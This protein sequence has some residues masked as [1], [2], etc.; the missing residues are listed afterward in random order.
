[1][2]INSILAL[3]ISL[4]VLSCG[5]SQSSNEQQLLQEKEAISQEKT[6]L[7]EENRKLR[8]TEE[9]AKVLQENQEKLQE[10]L[11]E[12]ENAREQENK[13][14][15]TP[16]EVSEI[17]VSNVT[18]EGTLIDEGTLFEYSKVKYIKYYYH[19]IDNAVIAGKKTNGA[20]YYRFLYKENGDWYVFNSRGSFITNTGTEKSYT[21]KGNNLSDS[22]ERYSEGSMYGSQSGYNFK[23]GKWCIDIW[24]DPNNSGAA[25]MLNQTF[26]EIY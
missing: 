11:D 21:I 9:Q 16:L 20:L 22:R 4:L 3:L 1:M 8:E 13:A 24:Y 12:Q 10:Q 18:S 7:E 25:Y 17:E 2:K 19:C 14:E 23:R 6:R 15:T 26:F 5:Q